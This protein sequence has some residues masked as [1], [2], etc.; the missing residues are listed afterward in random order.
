MFYLFRAMESARVCHRCSIQD[1]GRDLQ[2]HEK[3]NR[4]EEYGDRS[5]VEGGPG[6][7]SAR[8]KAQY[9]RH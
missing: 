1:K 3:G 8:M 5:N 9:K 6:E 2:E 4:M 7:A